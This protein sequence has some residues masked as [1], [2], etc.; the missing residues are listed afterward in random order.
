MAIKE[1]GNYELPYNLT[2]MGQKELVESH[3][4]ATN[5]HR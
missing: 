2:L 1:Q 4:A 3:Y 5:I